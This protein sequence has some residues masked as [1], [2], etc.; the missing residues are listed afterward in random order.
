MKIYTRNGDAGQTDLLAA[1]RV[2]KDHY[3]VEALGEIDELNCALGMVR[4]LGASPEE[5]AVLESVQK[6][7]FRIGSELA[8]PA[9]EDMGLTKIGGGEI[10]ALEELADRY[11]EKL[12]PFQWVFPSGPPAAAACQLARA[13]CRRA[14][15]RVVT[16]VRESDGEVSGE[17]ARYL[18]RLS[19][20]L[21]VFG[22]FLG[23]R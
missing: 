17:I 14:E 13:V 12:S 7:L 10:L 1:G 20:F 16:A 19:D 6:T 2:A 18:N 15:R 8:C 22:R 5:D 11:S 23:E 4:A 21:F 3:R 9:P